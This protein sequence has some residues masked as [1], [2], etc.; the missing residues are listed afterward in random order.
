MEKRT[1]LFSWRLPIRG[2]AFLRGNRD[3]WS[4]VQRSTDTS[5]L[6]AEPREQT[7]VSESFRC[8]GRLKRTRTDSRQAAATAHAGCW[9]RI[10]L[11]ILRHAALRGLMRAWL[12]S[13]LAFFS[14]D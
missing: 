7:R 2:Y 11:L 1:E 8:I 10:R 14:P 5:V 12:G 6:R 3:K 4:P 9:H 13:H